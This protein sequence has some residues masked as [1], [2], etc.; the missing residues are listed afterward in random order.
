MRTVEDVGSEDKIEGTKVGDDVL[1]TDADTVFPL[2]AALGYDITQ[3][4]FVGKHTLLVEGPS[5]LLYIRFFSRELQSRGRAP[6][7]PRWTIA[8][9]G[10]IDKISSFVALFGG[11]QLHV[12]VVTDFHEGE[13]RKIRELKESQLLQQGHVFSAE[14]YAGQPEADVEDL[15][16]WANYMVLVNETYGL[17][18]SNRLPDQK[19]ATAAAT[20]IRQVEEHF[21]TLQAPTPEFDHYAP[22]AYLLENA[23]ALRPQLPDLESALDRFERLFAD[24][25]A[26]LPAS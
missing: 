1:S 23:P 3:S 19:P 9:A 17:Q 24:L 8:P 7:D 22:A 18:G 13:K 5:D 12:A 6:L 14:T 15:I 10:G 26:L 20:A 2:Q 16:G 4:L 21:R 11:N 25:N